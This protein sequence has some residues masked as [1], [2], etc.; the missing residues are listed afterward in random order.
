MNEFD[1]FIFLE[2]EGL[3]RKAASDNV[4]RLKRIEKAI[5][6]CDIDDEY[7]KDNCEHLL[8]LFSNKGENEEMK[9]VLIGQLPIGSYS[10]STFR[11]AI[12]KYI[13]FMESTGIEQK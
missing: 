10:L 8:S 12:R 4:S 5:K 1:F 9:K 11:Y 2:K 13:C 6:D 7:K 3:S